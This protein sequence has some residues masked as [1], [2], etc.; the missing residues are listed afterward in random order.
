VAKGF[1]DERAFSQAFHQSAGLAPHQWL[2]YR[3][4]DSA[5]DL[6][7]RS[8]LSLAEIASICGFASK[9]HF[10]RV[11]MQSEGVSPAVWRGRSEESASF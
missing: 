11:F 7:R 4:I 9:T 10:M 8:E 2:L 3:R 6:L 5:K 1:T